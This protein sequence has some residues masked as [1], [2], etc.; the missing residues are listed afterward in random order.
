MQVVGLREGKRIGRVK[1]VILDLQTG[2]VVGFRLRTHWR[3][4][5][6]PFGRVK[7]IGPDAITV[8][9]ADELQ[10]PESLPALAALA[11]TKYRWERCEV[12]TENGLR[13][14]T[15]SWRHLWYNRIDGTAE[16]AV[17]SFQQ[18]LLN[19]LLSW[20]IEL[21]SMSLPLGDWIDR[22]GRLSVRVP[23]RTVR[24]ATRRMT[25]LNAEGETQFQEGL[26]AQARL[27]RESIDRSHGKLKEHLRWRW[28][29]SFGPPPESGL[30]AS[31]TSPLVPKAGS[32]E[33]ML[34]RPMD[35][36]PS[37]TS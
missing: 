34:D 8:E 9:S 37:K 33:R 7:S 14:G 32:E 35:S 19:N 16:L 4:R 15:T 22:P 1:D 29:G 3:K 10:L 30:S 13:L 23:L 27:T 21:A 20:A 18:S 31:V 17:E 2:R 5:L 36:T 28:R 26:Q 11:G 24:T 25:I 12:V 6:L